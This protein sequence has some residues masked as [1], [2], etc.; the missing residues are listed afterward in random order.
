MFVSI[1]DIVDR[2]S[3]SL[4][5]VS[6]RIVD[7]HLFFCFFSS[8]RRHT[9]FD[10]DWS[11]DVCSSDLGVAVDCEAAEEKGRIEHPVGEPAGHLAVDLP[12]PNGRVT[13]RACRDMA[14]QDDTPGA[15][16]EQN[17]ERLAYLDVVAGVAGARRA[18]RGE[19]S[20]EARVDRPGPR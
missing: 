6:V 1:V 16:D 15:D 8:R 3:G 19:H 18:R 11:S 2:D 10:Y 14:D 4:S 9:R 13:C 12:A 20:P 17:L 5:L 7:C